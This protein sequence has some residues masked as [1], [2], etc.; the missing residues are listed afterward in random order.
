MWRWEGVREGVKMRRCERRCEEEQ[1]WRGAGVKMRRCEDEKMWRWE[2]VKMSRCEDEKVWRWGVKMRRCED[3]VWRW[4]GVKMRRC[5]DEK[6]WRWED[7]IQT[8][9]IGR[10]LRSDALGKNWSS[11]QL[12]Y[13][14]WALNKS[15]NKF[16][17]RSAQV[18][19]APPGCHRSTRPAHRGPISSPR[20]WGRNQWRAGQPVAPN[21]LPLHQRPSRQ[22]ERHSKSASKNH[23]SRWKMPWQRIWWREAAQLRS[24]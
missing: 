7:E 14:F 6:V 16:I 4:E 23:R 11:S 3:E 13:L 19:A 1:M 24:K 21:H 5:E 12:A 17:A 18:A 9:T 20:I 2:D 15:F 8:P 22:L 10:T